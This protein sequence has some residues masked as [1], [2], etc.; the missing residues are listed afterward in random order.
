M[1]TEATA[2]ELLDVIR[3]VVRAGRTAR[4]GLESEDMPGWKAAVLGMLAREGEQRLGQVATYLEVDPSVASRQVATLEQLGLV[5]RRPDPADG[6]AQLLAVTAAGLAAFRGYRAQR[7][8]WVA[9]A[10]DSWDD[11]EVAHLAARLQELV[12]DLHCALAARTRPA[13]RAARPAS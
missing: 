11:A 8:Q 4:L 7:A 12:A 6:R 5:T 9:E 1:I 3:T 2:D 13:L 10:L